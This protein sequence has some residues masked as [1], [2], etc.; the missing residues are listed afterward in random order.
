MTHEQEQASWE[1]EPATEADRGRLY[2]FSGRLCIRRPLGS[3]ALE[4]GGAVTMWFREPN[5][6]HVCLFSCRFRHSDYS[7]GRPSMFKRR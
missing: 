1:G 4:F 6:A 2:G 7:T 5:H 3:L